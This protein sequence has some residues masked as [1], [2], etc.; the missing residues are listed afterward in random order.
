[1]AKQIMFDD[2]ARQKMRAGIE[3]LAK[4]VRVTLGPAGRNVIL[5]KSFGAPSVT[6]D[7]VSVAE[8]IQL[9]DPYACLARRG[10][11]LVGLY[12]KLGTSAPIVARLGFEAHG[13]MTFW[14]RAPG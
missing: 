7:G 12:A 13:R 5:Q 10:I 8:E 1:M 3:K 14:D 9:S 6:K 4:T 11:A 2:N